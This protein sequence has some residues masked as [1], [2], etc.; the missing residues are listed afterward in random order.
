MGNAELVDAM[1][2]ALSDPFDEAHMGVT[3]ERVAER[4]QISREAQDALAAQSH[5]RAARRD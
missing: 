4:Y 1:L 5:Q 3:A 2:G